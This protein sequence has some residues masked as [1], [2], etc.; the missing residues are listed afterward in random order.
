MARSRP[1]AHKPER[2]IMLARPEARAELVPGRD[3]DWDES[4]AG[5][6]PE[7][8]AEIAATDPLYILYTS[9]TTGQPKGIVRDHGGHAVALHWSMKNVYDVAPGEVYWAASDVG[10]VVGHSYICLRPAAPRQHDDRLRG[11]A[12]RHPRPRRVLAGDRAARGRRAV[13]R[14]DR[15]PGD[16][17]GGPER[18]P[19]R[20]VRPVEVPHAVPGRRALRSG[21]AALGRGA[22]ERAR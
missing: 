14:A 18:R 5:A 1:R 22:A 6:R 3:L 10:W 9:G 15:V 12:R 8:C 4:L 17:E 7:G 21:H 16:Q 20:E 2:C 11:Q 19:H 13:H